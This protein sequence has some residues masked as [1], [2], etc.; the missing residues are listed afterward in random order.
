MKLKSLAV[1]IALS[2]SSVGGASA[3]SLGQTFDYTTARSA[4]EAWFSG[5]KSYFEGMNAGAELLSDLTLTANAQGFT[6]IFA[7][8][9]S[10]QVTKFSQTFNWNSTRSG[11]LTVSG[12]VPV[13]G[14]EA[15]AGLGALALAG[16]A[17]AIRRRR[18]ANAA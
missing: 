1:V 10:P 11:D 8:L 15:G 16:V 14:P 17:Y 13:P 12:L 2:L 9:Y 18:M 5:W 4:Y 6:K 3:A 7:E